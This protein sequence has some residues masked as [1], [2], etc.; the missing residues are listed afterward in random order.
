M[1]IRNFKLNFDPIQ[2]ERVR[3]HVRFLAVR[4]IKRD[5]FFFFDVTDDDAGNTA[6]SIV[7]VQCIYEDDEDQT[8]EGEFILKAKRFC[9]ELKLYYKVENFYKNKNK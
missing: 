3:G 5:C 9:K 4:K 6:N 2:I 7:R 1:K 8:P